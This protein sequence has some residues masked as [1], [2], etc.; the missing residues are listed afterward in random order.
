M[1]SRTSAG[2]RWKKSSHSS[3]HQANCV[4]IAGTPEVIAVR[5]S[6]DPD[7][8]VL[9][10]SRNTFAAFIADTKRGRLG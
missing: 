6:K 9:S 4:E 3:P 8:A 10:F 1:Y 5:D 2:H 7:G